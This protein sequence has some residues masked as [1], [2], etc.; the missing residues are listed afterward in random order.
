MVSH[1]RHSQSTLA[2]FKSPWYLCVDLVCSVRHECFLQSI[3]AGCPVP[4][5]RKRCTHEPRRHGSLQRCL[6][7]F[8]IVGMAIRVS[9]LPGDY[10]VVCGGSASPRSVWFVRF[11]QTYQHAWAI[12]PCVLQG[13]PIF[14]SPSW[15]HGCLAARGRNRRSS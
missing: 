7:S 5:G 2:L 3:P 10:D 12:A 1:L 9:Y 15:P 14:G 6:S 8:K 11:G 13:S 4:S